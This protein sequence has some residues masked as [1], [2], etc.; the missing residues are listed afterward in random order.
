M[1]IIARKIILDRIDN[2]LKDVPH[3]FGIEDINIMFSITI[4]KPEVENK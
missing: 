4:K 3:R 1:D 2:E